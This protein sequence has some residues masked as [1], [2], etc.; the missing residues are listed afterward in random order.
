MLLLTLNVILNLSPPLVPELRR[1]LQGRVSLA[2]YQD[3]TN[4][5]RWK[6]AET[7]SA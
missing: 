7:S 2:M 3:L 6:D 5:L 1:G 4:L